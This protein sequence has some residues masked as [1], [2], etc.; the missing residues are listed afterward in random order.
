MPRHRLTPNLAALAPAGRPG[1]RVLRRLA[2]RVWPAR[3]PPLL[4]YDQWARRYAS[5]GPD[6]LAALRRRLDHLALRPDAPRFALVWALPAGEAAAEPPALA[7]LRGQIYPHWELLV[8][9]DPAL[10][11]PL[12][13]L[14]T[15]WAGREPRCRLLGAGGGGQNTTALWHTALTAAE[16]GFLGL[17]D[18]AGR[19]APWALSLLA[20]RLA[21]D[22]AAGQ[23]RLI[24]CDEEVRDPAGRRAPCF[25][26][27]WSP[28]NLLSHNYL[29]Q[30][31][32][33]A[34]DLLE[35]AGGW[36]T[37]DGRAAWYG[38]LLRAAACL[39]PGEAVH[40]PQVLLSR[41]PEPTPVEALA[42]HLAQTA[43]GAQV[44]RTGDPRSHRVVWP[45]LTPAPLVS[46]IIPT[47]GSAA[48]LPGLLAHLTDQAAYPP[49]EVLLLANN[50]AGPA[51]RA[52]VVEAARLPGVRVLEQTGPFSHSAIYNWAVPQ[53]RGEVLALL[54]DDLEA[55]AEDW[56]AEMTGWALRPAVGAVGALLT[57]PSGVIQHLGVILGVGGAA[58][59]LGKG[60]TPA[61]LPD[62]GALFQVRNVGAVTAACLVL[63]R[64]V[65]EAVGGFD[66]GLPTS[67]NDVDLCLAIRARGWRV[68]VTPHARLIHHESL[69]RG[70]LRGRAAARRLARD[71]GYLRAKWGEA[72]D[73]DPY[74]SPNYSL[75][76]EKL[77]L[78]VPP[79]VARPWQG[80]GHADA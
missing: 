59:H 52:R 38:L 67:F 30:G 14:L 15:A 24:S 78:A 76:S 35:E 70:Y 48:T 71:R 43:P 75:A 80:E 74:F 16:G 31:V 39:A 7:A 54:N 46:V 69:S 41:E 56:L 1:R 4:S 57:Y 37:P 33:L 72:L 12:G 68:V 36:Q 62:Q 34:R 49:R 26:P 13:P 61:A 58:G 66:P 5:P 27:A 55:V 2:G 10:T 17:L 60:L 40:V 64:E 77:D 8:V 47:T 21:A 23:V 51:A 63:R 6:Q 32:F 20:E 3:F 22:R 50:L 79:R 25:K 42:G 18:P 29:G 28:D 19:L 11:G 9:G 53:S 65:Y 73:Q 44:L 45:Q